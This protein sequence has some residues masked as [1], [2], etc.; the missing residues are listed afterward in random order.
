MV[1]RPTNRVEDSTQDAG[2]G[3]VSLHHYTSVVL[4]LPE[5]KDT[6]YGETGGENTRA[7]TVSALEEDF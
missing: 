6:T 1:S 5:S 2:D 7:E 4:G 3:A